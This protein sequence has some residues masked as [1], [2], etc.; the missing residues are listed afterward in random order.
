VQLF[1]TTFLQHLL[2]SNDGLKYGL[3][4]NDMAT[5]NV[6][7][8]LIKKQT[9]SGDFKGIDTVELQNGCVCW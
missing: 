2:K 7:S 9:M 8:K 5:V 6:D 4:V 1:Q 3:V